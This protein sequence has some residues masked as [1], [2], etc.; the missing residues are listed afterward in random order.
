[1]R[2]GSTLAASRVLDINQ[3]TVAR[4]IDVLE[5]TLGLT[6]FEKTTR[7]S[8]PT[9]QA[10]AL[11]RAAEALETSVGDFAKAAAKQRDTEAS[12]VRIT[13]VNSAFNEHFSAI[14]SEF[15]ETNSNVKFSL[16]PSDKKLDIS[17]GET[18]IAIR[19]ASTSVE[20]DPNLICRRIYE[21]R[22]S[23][24]A[25]TGYAEKYGLPQSEADLAGHQFC[26]FGDE[27]RTHTA[28][29]WLLPKIE[30]NQIAMT[31]R[32]IYAMATGVRMG[33]GIGTLPTR[34]ARN[35]PGMLPCFELPE[36]TGSVVWL[37]VNP[38]AYKRPEV[39]A[40]TKFFAPRYSEYYRSS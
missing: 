2:E 31:C 37:L 34:F 35:D 20:I 25:S 13:A 4:R 18:D 27:L 11:L 17:K 7:G 19:L 14:L 16:L 22:I 9:P 15:S 10:A 32:D 6:L 12:V 29:K 1:M 36:G 33:A 26:V 21:L 5:H 28:N 8:E 38:A 3:T 24:L 40:F 39:K 23:L 30:E